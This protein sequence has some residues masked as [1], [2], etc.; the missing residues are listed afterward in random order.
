MGRCAKIGIFDFL[1]LLGLSEFIYLLTMPSPITY[2]KRCAKYA[3]LLHI[4]RLLLQVNIFHVKTM[5]TQK[6]IYNLSQKEDKM[7]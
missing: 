1:Y 7:E 6:V 5:K 2:L 3:N 4:L